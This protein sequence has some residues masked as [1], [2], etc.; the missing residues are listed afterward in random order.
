MKGTRVYAYILT[1]AVKALSRNQAL[2]HHE[3]LFKCLL[4]V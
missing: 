2:K 1:A 4:K 3:I